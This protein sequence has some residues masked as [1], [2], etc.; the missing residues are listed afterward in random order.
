M[1]KKRKSMRM[2]CLRMEIYYTMPVT[3]WLQ[4]SV[5]FE[6]PGVGVTFFL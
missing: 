2:D 1:Y 4:I 5:F 3:N 6:F